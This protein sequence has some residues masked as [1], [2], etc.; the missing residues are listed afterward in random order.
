MGLRLIVSGGGTGG[1]I[2]PAISIAQAVKAA[3]PDAE[4]LFVGAEGRMEMEKVPAA[5]FDIVGLPVVGIQRSFTLK[6]LAVPF[7]LLKSLRQARRIIKDF[8]PD[9]VVGVGGYASGPTLYA[10][11]GMGIPTLIQEQNSFAGLTNKLL[12]R[13]AKKICVAY[14]GM[15]KFFPKEKIMLTGNPVR[16]DLSKR[17]I[18]G[19]RREAQE[20]FNLD[21]CKQTIL[22]LGGSLGAKTI[23]TSISKNLDLLAHSNV[24]L[25]WQTGKSYIF[26][27]RRVLSSYSVPNV[28]A[29]DFIY[30]MDLAYAA[31][32]LVVSRAGAGT[33]SEL[34]L[35]GKPCILVP[36]PNVAEDHQTKN[37]MS[38]VSREAAVM[39][40]DDEAVQ[41]LVAAAIELVMDN[42]H[43]NALA[44]N[45]YGLALTNSATIIANEVIKL[46]TEKR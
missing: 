43:L 27:A 33:I 40:N 30:S 1:H 18:N 11:S 34:C 4:I 2:F 5:G 32:D 44:E 38:L 15:E 25:I 20:F 6:N 41:K 42:Q 12:A 36:S 8:N 3:V 39:V 10:A 16:S 17:K 21:P 24:Q 35:V 23:N 13:R 9:V 28:K 22:V 31:A 14:E 37:A 45:V 26:D 19:L 7:K 46:A 29:F